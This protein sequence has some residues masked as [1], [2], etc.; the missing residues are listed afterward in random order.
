MK[1]K[2]NDALRTYVVQRLAGHDS[3][4]AIMRALAEDHGVV[5]SN[6]SVTR[7]DPTSYNGQRSCGKRWRT[8]FFTTRAAIEAGQAEIAAANKMVRVR[9]LDFMA[10]DAMDRRK[11]RAARELLA[12]V[13]RELGQRDTNQTLELTG[14]GGGPIAV[15]GVSDRDRARAVLALINKVKAAAAAASEPAPRGAAEPDAEES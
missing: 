14:K 10:R 5:I 1:S 4:G 3:P 15:A 2:L 8:L 9:W 7:Y 6:Q 13:A 12:D 11:Y